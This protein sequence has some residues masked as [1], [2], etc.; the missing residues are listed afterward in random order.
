MTV[1][2]FGMF[3]LFFL[4]WLFTGGEPR[5]VSHIV[6]FRYLDHSWWKELGLVIVSVAGIVTT[7]LVSVVAILQGENHSPRAPT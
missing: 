7:A 4:A 2:I 1:L 6:P 5:V 3:V